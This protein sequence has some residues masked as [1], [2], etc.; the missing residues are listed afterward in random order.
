M[1]LGELKHT[2]RDTGTVASD[3]KCITLELEACRFGEKFTG[4][5]SL[6]YVCRQ[7][8]IYFLARVCFGGRSLVAT[9][10][11]T[12]ALTSWLYADK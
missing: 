6:D 12:V 11:D 9:W 2:V 3:V 8:H 4:H 7:Q 1:Q 10:S 5:L